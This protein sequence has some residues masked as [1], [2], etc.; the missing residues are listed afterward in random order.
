MRYGVALGFLLCLVTLQPALAQSA[1]ERG[2]D[3]A[4]RL[5]GQ[6]HGLGA[7]DTSPHRTAPA[8]RRIGA[9]INLDELEQRLREGILAGH[10]E[11]PAFVLR[12]EEARAMVVYLRSIRAN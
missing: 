3:L 12:Q 4:A 5:C 11:M 1:A 7:A 2:R 9:R 8:F 10:P 6:C